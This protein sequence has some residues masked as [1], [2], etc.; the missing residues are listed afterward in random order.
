MSIPSHAAE[1][2]GEYPQFAEIILDLAEIYRKQLTA[3]LIKM[4]WDALHE[5]GI[6]ALRTAVNHHLADIDVGHLWPLPSRLLR[7]IYDDERNPSDPPDESPDRAAK[8]KFYQSYEWREIRYD[9]LQKHGGQCLLCGRSRRHGVVIHVDH[10][11]PLSADWSRR[12]DPDNLQVLCEDCN[13]GKSNRDD[14]DW[15]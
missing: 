12:L 11:V 10:I 14:T 13:L 9:V 8:T 2:R 4:Y 5:C 7:I 1:A 6:P 3:G 15:R